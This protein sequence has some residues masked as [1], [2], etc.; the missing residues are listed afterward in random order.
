MKP[1]ILFIHA[2]TPDTPLFTQFYDYVSRPESSLDARIY[3]NDVNMPIQRMVAAKF[4]GIPPRFILRGLP[5]GNAIRI[6][7]DYISKNGIKII[8]ELGDTHNFVWDNPQSPYLELSVGD[9]EVDYLIARW[10]KTEGYTEEEEPLRRFMDK[11]KQ[12]RRAELIY[13]PWGINPE[14]YEGAPLKRDI[15][16]SLLG[17]YYHKRNLSR[18]ALS[19]LRERGF[20]VVLSKF[21]VPSMDETYGDKYI[22]LL[23]RSKIFLVLG[24]HRQ[25]QVF[26][27]QKYLEGAASGAML[28][29][30]IPYTGKDVFEDGVSIVEAKDEQDRVYEKYTL[31]DRQIQYYLEHDE[32]RNRIALEGRRRVLETFS[33]DKVT[34]EFEEVLKRG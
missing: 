31:V 9:V 19:R 12:L 7:A 17:R 4:G 21:P 27:T 16:V 10:R 24:G 28:L 2:H 29:G 22:N 26:L 32:E 13:V 18:E 23:R 15:D 30:D 20:K 1:S 25:H 3:S 33:L 11:K 6:S 34:R 5:L 8:L 14:I